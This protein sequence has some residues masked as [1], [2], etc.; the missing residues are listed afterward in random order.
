MSYCEDN[1]SEE[2]WEL[3]IES[4]WSYPSREYFYCTEIA[5]YFY[6]WF[7]SLIT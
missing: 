7:L 2:C 5:N 6:F 1:T 3:A 4:F